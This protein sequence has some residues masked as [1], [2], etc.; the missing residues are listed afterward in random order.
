MDPI[1]IAAI[2]ASTAVSV[3]QQRKA[4]KSAAGRAEDERNIVA[5]EKQAAAKEIGR[6]AIAPK[7][8]VAVAPVSEKEDDLLPEERKKTLQRGRIALIRTSP[9][10]ILSTP[11]TGRRKLLGN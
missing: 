8:D 7:A 2:V 9:R 5:S 11:Q 6:A 4:Q 10:G 1:V 3:S